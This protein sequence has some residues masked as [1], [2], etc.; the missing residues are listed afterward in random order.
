MTP[1]H[2]DVPLKKTTKTRISK[3]DRSVS[4]DTCKGLFYKISICLLIIDSKIPLLLFAKNQIKCQP[5]T[6][7]DNNN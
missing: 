1:K 5:T 3:S 2:Y 6:L 4:C 7:S